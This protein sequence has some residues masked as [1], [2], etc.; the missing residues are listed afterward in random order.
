MAKRQHKIKIFLSI[1]KISYFCQKKIAKALKNSSF[2]RAFAV[3]SIFI[4]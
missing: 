4:R 3:D 2:F 1:G